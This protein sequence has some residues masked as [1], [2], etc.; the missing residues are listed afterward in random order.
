MKKAEKQIYAF[1]TMISVKADSLKEAVQIFSDGMSQ[2]WVYDNV[3]ELT[4]DGDGEVDEDELIA[5]QK[6]WYKGLK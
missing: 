4:E 2:P 1:T 6:A 3:V 5:A